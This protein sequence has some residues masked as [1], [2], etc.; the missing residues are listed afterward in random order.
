MIRARRSTVRI[1]S[2]CLGFA[3]IAGF[4]YF[5]HHR[6]AWDW[7]APGTGKLPQEIVAGFLA[8]T[9]EQGRGAAAMQGYFAPDAVDTAPA[10]PN[11]EDGAPMPHEVRSVIAQGQTVVV[12]HRIAAARGQPSQDVIDVFETRRGRIVRRDR[13]YTQF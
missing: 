11:Q 7:D 3:F 8:E 13:F 10:G 5:F 4:Y 1:L 6:L 2:I 9:H 12:I